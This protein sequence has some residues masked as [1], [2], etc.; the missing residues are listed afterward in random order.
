MDRKLASIQAIESLTPIQDADSIV[1][2]KMVDLGWQVVVRKD[3]F[4]AGDKVIYT[5]I[6]SLLPEL[7][8]YEFLRK[9][10]YKKDLKGFRIRTSKLR[11]VISYGLCLPVL[12]SL[13]DLPTG[14]DVTEALGVRKWE[15]PMPAQLRGKIRGP[16]KRLCVPHTDETRVQ[17]IPHVLKR[18][19]GETFQITE[20]C[21]GTSMS[22]YLDPETG[23]HVCS[24]NVDLAPDFNHKFNGT[25]YWDYAIKHNL[26]EI[27]KQLGNT[28]ALQGELIGP[29]IAGE[30]KNGYKLIDYQYR[31]FNMWDTK[32]HVYIEHDTMLDTCQT[33]GLGKDFLVP[34]LGEIILD[35]TVDDIINM[36]DGK[37]LINP[38]VSREGIVLR[39]IPEQTDINLGRLSFKGISGQYLIE[40][41]KGGD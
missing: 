26:E 5:E 36:A 28:I 6:D 11:G 25:A 3:Q 2:A 10:C 8:E 4:R 15:P 34:Q 24:R 23:M 13:K 21:D 31:V 29:N 1:L 39:A 40:S 33:F 12:G 32:N 17:T 14:S 19:E 27:L 30:K 18:H 37:S 41:R 35:H 22:V 7:P 38:E 20:K 9:C 16:M